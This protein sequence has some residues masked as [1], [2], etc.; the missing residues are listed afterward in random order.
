VAVRVVAAAREDRLKVKA[1]AAREADTREGDT[2]AAAAR[3]AT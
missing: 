1:A 3:A 2:R